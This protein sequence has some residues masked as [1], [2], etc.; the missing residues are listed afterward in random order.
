MFL[1]AKAGLLKP[2]DV[3]KVSYGFMA[4]KADAG[5]NTITFR[6][7]TPGLYEGFAISFAGIVILSAYFIISR[8]KKEK[9]GHRHYYNY[10]SCEN[11]IRASLEYEKSF[12]NKFKGD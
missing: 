2:V 6:Y 8:K 9:N 1:T 11:K 5:Q 7:R 3:E 10:N 4:V 12:E